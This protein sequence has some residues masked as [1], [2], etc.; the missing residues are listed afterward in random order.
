MNEDQCLFEDQNSK[1][2][3]CE[4]QEDP[5]DFFS[6]TIKYLCS[7][8]PAEIGEIVSKRDCRNG[9]DRCCHRVCIYNLVFIH[10]FI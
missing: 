5:D 8:D 4:A 2:S 1:V 7:L 3:L 10:V 6:P 9:A